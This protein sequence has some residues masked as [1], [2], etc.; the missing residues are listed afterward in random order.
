MKLF[1]HLPMLLAAVL[2]R[3]HMLETLL[4]ALL[5]RVLTVTFLLGSGLLKRGCIIAV[6]FCFTSF[7]FSTCKR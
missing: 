4:A 5:R 2:T 3:L 1:S 7:R 6:T